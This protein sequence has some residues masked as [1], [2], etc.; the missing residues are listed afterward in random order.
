MRY[1]TNIT[2][3]IRGTTMQKKCSLRNCDQHAIG[4]FQETFETGSLTTKGRMAPGDTIYWCPIHESDL[5]A[6]T[7][8][9]KGARIAL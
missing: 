2:N 3:W 4:G 7:Q 5:L 6:S 9:M 1:L 8:T